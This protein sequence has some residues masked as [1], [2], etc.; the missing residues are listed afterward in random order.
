M[1]DENNTIINSILPD[2]CSPAKYTL[3]VTIFPYENELFYHALVKI[4]CKQYSRK[5][6]I[7]LNS[8]LTN[9]SI[10]DIK[11]LYKKNLF[12]ISYTIENEYQESIRIKLDGVNLQ[13]DYTEFTLFFNVVGKIKEDKKAL[14]YWDKNKKSKEQILNDTKIKNI[15]DIVIANCFAPAEARFFIPCF[16]FPQFKSEFSLTILLSKDFNE[17]QVIS[18]TEK[19]KEE[20]YMIFKHDTK[21]KIIIAHEDNFMFSLQKYSS[22]SSQLKDLNPKQYHLKDFLVHKFK[23][24]PLM[25]IYLLNITI[26]S[27]YF[28]SS[29]VNRKNKQTVLIRVFFY[30]KAHVAELILKKAIEAF[31]FYEDYFN[32]EFPMKKLDLILLPNLE[33]SGMENWGSILFNSDNC[34]VSSKPSFGQISYI[35]EIT[36]HEVSHMWFGNLVTMKSFRDLWLNE[37]FASFMEFFATRKIYEDNNLNYWSHF[38]WKRGFLENL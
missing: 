24:T 19:I 31:I 35:S 3:V 34:K 18:N 21:S 9:Y 37:G 23:K 6:Y 33:F 1:Q 10:I 4:K 7:V 28:K 14:F 8:V 2:G 11:I 12:N 25:S 20:L 36:Y 13:E 16:D 29:E 27:L 30:K 26:G 5:D 38:L 15:S 32:I 22:Q 17:M